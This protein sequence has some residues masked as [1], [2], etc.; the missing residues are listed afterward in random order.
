M[1]HLR[2]LLGYQQGQVYS[3]DARPTVIGR[4]PSS[5][6]ILDS[7]S[8]AS[9]RHAEIV[10]EDG[11]WTLCDLGSRNG[12]YLN[13]I[14]IERSPL[15]HLD[16]V[17]LGDSL[18]I[19]EYNDRLTAETVA[20]ASRAMPRSPLGLQNVPA[21]QELVKQVGNTFANCPALVREIMTAIIAGGHVLL[22]RLADSAA[23][24]ILTT[25][26]RI[27]ELGTGSLRFH[28]SL[29]LDELVKGNVGAAHAQV[30]AP[31]FTNV[32][33]AEDI[34][35]ASGDVQA[36]MV[37]TMKERPMRGISQKSPLPSPFCILATAEAPA[38]KGS[39]PFS[40]AIL[41]HFM[42][43]V[44]A[45]PNDAVQA[46]NWIP[47]F[48]LSTTQIADLVSAVRDSSLD[49]SLVNFAAQIA[50]ATRPTHRAAPP[51][52]KRYVN[53]GAGPNA[54]YSL[55]I[56]A[57][58]RAVTSGRIIANSGD[59]LSVAPAVLRHRIILKSEAADEA[60]DVERI[61]RKLL[62][63]DPCEAGS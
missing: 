34:D 10:C 60:V 35:K 38:S 43:S 36:A 57:K 21:I 39:R 15:N 3:L 8:P 63:L 53:S 19:F 4:D 54:A 62:A 1:P 5:E 51:F 24:A 50:C 47:H 20:A 61:I 56:G 13:G 12:T 14:R 29:A 55:L 45:E 25:I 22:P 9:R 26:R 33:M 2:V 52:V 58:A 23:S 7:E 40:P 44:N 6:I 17:L 48:A 46:A 18:F 30:D 37:D 32:F 41:D 11:E 59:I 28:H 27:S 49:E 31:L 16:E 42:F